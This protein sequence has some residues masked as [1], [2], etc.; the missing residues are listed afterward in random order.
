MKKTKEWWEYKLGE[1]K[2][3]IDEVSK[4]ILGEKSKLVKIAYTFLGETG[5][6]EV[7]MLKTKDCPEEELKKEVN[8]EK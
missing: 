3:S 6:T 8:N 5:Q 2:E 7:N 4:L 1:E